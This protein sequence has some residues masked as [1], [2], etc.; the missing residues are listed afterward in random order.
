M[1]ALPSP[2]R[3]PV[4]PPA[5]GDVDDRQGEARREEGGRSAEPDEGDGQ[6]GREGGGTGHGREGPPQH[7]P[8]NRR[9][10]VAVRAGRHDP[11]DQRHTREQAGQPRTEYARGGGQPRHEQPGERGAHPE[12]GSCRPPGRDG[13]DRGCVG[14]PHP[15][16]D[17]CHR[18][19]GEARPCEGRAGRVG[20]GPE[21][22]S[23]R[24]GGGQG[25]GRVGSCGRDRVGARER[26]HH[27]LT[28]EDAARG[29]GRGRRPVGEEQ[30]QDQWP[31]GER[32]PDKPTSETGSDPVLHPTGG[33]DD[34]GRED[35]TKDEAFHAFDTS[36]S[37]A[38]CGSVYGA[39]AGH[40]PG[41]PRSDRDVAEESATLP[42]W[43][44]STVRCC[45]SSSMTP[46]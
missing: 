45:A 44:P 36:T 33:E 27:H 12:L 13:R 28:G 6:D 5:G 31:G 22:N 30:Q 40:D 32:Q 24:R 16:R 46:A 37:V 25:R 35:E 2:E 23:D 39:A 11:H 4:V 19:D 26:H 18:Q 42:G 20:A 34:E 9:A 17:E 29:D 41:I 3:A 21:Q 7:G 15:E 1:T 38:D 10:R 43:T 8:S 14:S